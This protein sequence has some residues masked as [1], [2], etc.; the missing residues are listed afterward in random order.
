MKPIKASLV[1]T[2]TVLVLSNLI[3]A[4][5]AVA[6]SAAF[7]PVRMRLAEDY[8]A[9]TARNDG[10][11][12]TL[13][14]I[15]T[16]STALATAS[17]GM[18]EE[19]ILSR[20][21][22]ILPAK[23]FPQYDPLLLQAGELLRDQLLADFTALGLFVVNL[24]PPTAAGRVA[25]HFASLAHSQQGRIYGPVGQ[26]LQ[27]ATNTSQISKALLPTRRFLSSAQTSLER[28]FMAISS[29]PDDAFTA[30]FQIPR[31]KFHAGGATTASINGTNITLTLAGDSSSLPDDVR[32]D[33]EFSLSAS[34]V[35]PPGFAPDTF[36]ANIP[37]DARADLSFITE[38]GDFSGGA[39]FSGGVWAFI[40]GTNI[41][42]VFECDGD[43]WVIT[44]GHFIVPLLHLSAMEA[45]TVMSPRW[46]LQPVGSP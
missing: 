36:V 16:L 27:V 26:R 39:A 4:H 30:D 35:P 31:F 13:K 21:A 37:S 10:S 33:F 8:V 12:T 44:H 29:G 43:Q 14:N 20:L 3:G 5:S 34:W 18:S 17:N 38:G 40:R 11:K 15:R 19:F 42:G 45:E 6:E 2:T 41:V 23:R 25:G 24:P 28:F 1:V 9:F 46:R 32:Y 22:R 7:D